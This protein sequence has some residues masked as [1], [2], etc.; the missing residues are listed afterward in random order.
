MIIFII[1]LYISFIQFL[2][3]CLMIIGFKFLEELSESNLDFFSLYIS[4]L[5]YLE[6]NYDYDFFNFSDRYGMFKNFEIKKF[7][8]PA[9]TIYY[10]LTSAMISEFVRFMGLL[11]I[12]CY[13]FI[14]ITNLNDFF[15]FNFLLEIFFLLLNLNHT[16]AS[17]FHLTKSIFFFSY[18]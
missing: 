15:F 12:P 4:S 10:G 1:D 2:K 6:Y 18:F 17:M 3:K 5:M 8:T 9:L 16:L 14:I 7:L 13:L 11:I